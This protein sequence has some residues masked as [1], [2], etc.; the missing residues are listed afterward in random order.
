[1]RCPTCGAENEYIWVLATSVECT[2]GDCFHYSSKATNRWIDKIRKGNAKEKE[3]DD[4]DQT[5]LFGFSIGGKW[6]TPQD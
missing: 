2:E 5:D 4:D 3:G 1:M 6:Y